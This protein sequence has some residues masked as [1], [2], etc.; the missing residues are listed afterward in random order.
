MCVVVSGQEVLCWTLL[1]SHIVLSEQQDHA[2]QVE[3]VLLGVARVVALLCG[4]K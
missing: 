3:P 4:I 1:E 2:T